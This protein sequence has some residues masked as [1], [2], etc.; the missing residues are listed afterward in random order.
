MKCQ[1]KW[2][3]SLFLLVVSSN[4]LISNAFKSSTNNFVGSKYFKGKAS[5][6][7]RR[8]EKKTTQNSFPSNRKMRI[9]EKL[10]GS[11]PQ[12]PSPLTF[13]HEENK[14][15]KKITTNSIPNAPGIHSD[16]KTH[17]NEIPKPAGEHKEIEAVPTFKKEKKGSDLTTTESNNNS[18]NNH[19][20]D[21][22]SNLLSLVDRVAPAG[23]IKKEKAGSTLTNTNNSSHSEKEKEHNKINNKAD[24]HTSSNWVTQQDKQE[25]SSNS[26]NNVSKETIHDNNVEI[27]DNKSANTIPTLGALGAAATVGNLSTS[28]NANTNTSANSNTNSNANRKST[29]TKT[30]YGGFFD[31]TRKEN[32]NAAMKAL[33]MFLGGIACFFGSI[34]LICWNERRAVKEAE[35]TDY[36]SRKDECTEISNGAPIDKEN[37][38]SQMTYLVSG[39]L[40]IE[41]PAVIDGL[42]I[43]Y[44]TNNGRQIIVKY[45][46]DKFTEWDDTVQHENE[47]TGEISSSTTHKKGWFENFEGSNKFKEQ[48]FYGKAWIEGNYLVRLENIRHFVDSK[49]TNS[50]SDNKYIHIF[51]QEDEALLIEYLKDAINSN[52]E[53]K[54]FF[55][56]QFAYVIRSNAE[57]ITKENFNSKTY[58]F[59]VDDR[60]IH[61]KYVSL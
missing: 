27:K 4:I 39:K 47:Y 45:C 33:G 56:Q 46:V 48:V 29:S 6:N 57:K 60:R 16:S 38:N 51:K 40:E 34:H 31:K 58:N 23:E 19:S 3:I 35:F 54:I 20:S 24:E 13:R 14:V 37:F 15:D 53:M 28:N 1:Y 49:Q 8:V 25:K 44:S 36:I 7:V 11:I 9:K 50:V 43:N 41:K 2:I 21:N 5:K 17:L 61:I 10:P 18:L 30:S 32:E 42:N 12:N 26:I 55:E 59:S 22:N 52:I